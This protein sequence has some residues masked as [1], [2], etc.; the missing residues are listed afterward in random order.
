MDGKHRGGKQGVRGKDRNN[1]G[2]KSHGSRLHS[3]IG[4][5]DLICNRQSKINSPM[6]FAPIYALFK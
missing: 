1:S 2:S 5:R 3:G 4:R 6:L